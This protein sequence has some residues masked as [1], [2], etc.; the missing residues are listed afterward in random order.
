MREK[1]LLS[2]EIKS[3]ERIISKPKL[4]IKNKYFKYHLKLEQKDNGT[5]LIRVDN[6]PN[7]IEIKNYRNKLKAK[8]FNKHEIINKVDDE[9]KEYYDTEGRASFKQKM[10]K[11]AIIFDD[12]VYWVL[13]EK[14]AKWLMEKVYEDMDAI[15]IDWKYLFPDCEDIA[16]I[17]QAWALTYLF[18]SGFRKAG[19]GVGFAKIN[20]YNDSNKLKAHYLNFLP[21]FDNGKLE[22]ALYEPQNTNFHYT[23]TDYGKRQ[24]KRDVLLYHLSM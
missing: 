1:I 11:N 20:Y 17:A 15:G 13:Y 9:W 8:K 12:S 24:G 16:R 6:I 10:S 2:N 22:V 7:A 18:K 14:S 5:T 21:I 4:T 3:V 19:A 23:P